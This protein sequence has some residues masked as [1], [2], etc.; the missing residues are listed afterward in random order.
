MLPIKFHFKRG[1]DWGEG[2]ETKIG[3]MRLN[4]FRKGHVTLT[5]KGNVMLQ[6]NSFSEDLLAGKESQ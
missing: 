5:E 3:V 4:K 1:K 2:P 6:L